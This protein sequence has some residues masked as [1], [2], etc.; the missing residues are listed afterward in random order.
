VIDHSP[1]TMTLKERVADFLAWRDGQPRFDH[2]NKKAAAIWQSIL[3]TRPGKKLGRYRRLTLP[4]SVA[5]TEA[6]VAAER[7]TLY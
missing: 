4:R 7:E 5:L 2:L 3:P 1:E 6:E